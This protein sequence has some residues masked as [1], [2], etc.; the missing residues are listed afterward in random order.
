MPD[1]LCVEVARLCKVHRLQLSGI[2]PGFTHALARNGKRI[3]DGAIVV[4]ALEEVEAGFAIAHI[5]FR[6][7]RQWVG[8]V[9]LPASGSVADVLRDAITLCAVPPP[10]RTYVM[11]PVALRKW[12][13]ESP[14]TQWLPTPWDAAP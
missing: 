2:E 1:P 5:G 14:A 3:Q 10:D 9:S 12:V 13:A 8:F 7:Q 11:S 6:S 4:I